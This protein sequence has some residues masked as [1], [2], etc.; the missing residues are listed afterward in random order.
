MSV[1]YDTRQAN[2]NDAMAGKVAGIQLR[3]QSSSKLGTTG[4]GNVLLHGANSL[5]GASGLLYILD[6]VRVN[7]GDINTD[8]VK[9]V[10]LLSGA[11]ASVIYGPDAAGG[12]M[13]VTSK[14]GKG[15]IKKPKL[16]EI[17]SAKNFNE[18]AFFFPNLR[19]DAEGN[20]S[21][22]FTIPEALTKWKLMTLAHSKD[23]A[24]GYS[25]KT[26]ITQKPLMVQPNAPRFLREGDAM[27]FTA[28]IV[29]LGDSEVTGTAQLELLDA[30]TNKPVD[31]WFKNVFPSQYFTVAAGQSSVVKFPMEVPFNFNSAMTYR[32]TAQASNNSPLGDGGFSDGEEMALPV[33]TN[34]TLVTE[35]M[36]INL[37][38]QTTKSFKFDKLIN[39][40]SSNTSATMH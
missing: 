34:R 27:E 12:A 19:T 39:S 33:L 30:A 14:S 22:E 23:L 20:I 21:F 25:E 18:T 26:T 17:K 1:L 24:S 32:I 3:G 36:P 16:D 9:D 10:T 38:N 35:S 28:K 5:S 6:G 29:N 2:I 13:V 37:R 4:T 31:G 15:V 40:A 8:D 11:A 7:A